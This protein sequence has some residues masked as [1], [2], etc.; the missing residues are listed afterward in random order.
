MPPVIIERSFN[1]AIQY[2]ADTVGIDG[3]VYSTVGEN[4][5][6]SAKKAVT[7]ELSGEQL[8]QIKTYLVI[9]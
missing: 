2:P 6:K 1:M 3:T 4:I 8:T 7:D 5:R 9:S